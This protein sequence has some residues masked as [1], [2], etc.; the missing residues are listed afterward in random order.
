[1]DVWIELLVVVFFFVVALLS[2]YI[3][4]EQVSS[5]SC[6]QFV[7][8]LTH[9]SSHFVKGLAAVRTSLEISRDTYF[10]LFW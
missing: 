9:S 4:R 10:L 5:S 8:L 7:A 6:G 1:M 3:R 2:V